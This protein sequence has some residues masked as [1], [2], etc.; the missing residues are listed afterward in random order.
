MPALHR[1]DREFRRSRHARC[2]PAVEPMEARVLLAAGDLDLTFGIEGRVVSDF[3]GRVNVANDIAIQADGKIVVAGL[4]STPSSDTGFDFAVARYNSDGTLDATFGVGGIVTTDFDGWDDIAYSVLVQPDGKIVAA[5]GAEVNVDGSYVNP[6]V[7]LVRYNAD[8]SLDTTFGVDGRVVVV[9]GFGFSSSFLQDIALQ[10]DGRIV[11]AGSGSESSGASDFLIARFEA[12]GELD[13]TFGDAGIAFTDFFGGSDAAYGLAIQADGKIVAV[14]RA[15]ESE[16]TTVAAFARYNL[17]GSLDTTFA[18]GSVVGDG[19]QVFESNFSVTEARSVVLDPSDD[20]IIAAG[21]AGERASFSNGFSVARFTVLRLDTE[22]SPIG[23]M[24]GQFVPGPQSVVNDLAIDSEGRIII[25]GYVEP[26]APDPIPV[27]FALARLNS[28]LSMDLSFGSDG[29]VVTDFPGPP[30]PSRDSL[31]NAVAI[32]P[33][34]RI[35]AVGDFAAPGEDVDFALARYQVGLTGSF[36]FSSVT[37]HV[38]E[39]IGVALIPVLRTGGAEGTVTVQFSATPGTAAPPDFTPVLLTLTFEDGEVLQEVGIN[40]INDGI[41]EPDESIILTLFDPTNGA[42]LG[43]PSVAEMFILDDDSP[44]RLSIAPNVT[45]VE[46]D[47]GAT[48]VTL[49]ISLVGSTEVPASVVVSLVDGT[50]VAGLDFVYQPPRVLVFEPGIT[51][52]TYEVEV[53]GDL[54]IE[55]TEYFGVQ[56]S[57]PIES[58][59]EAGVALIFIEDDDST[60]VLNTNDSGIGSLR[61]AIEVANATPDRQVIDFAI[62]GPGPHTI[63]PLSS[64]PAITD[65]VSID[66]RSQDGYAGTPLIEIAGHML[67]EPLD[68]NGLKIQAAYTLVC[69]IAINRFPGAGIRAEGADY[70]IVDS[71]HIGTDPSGRV[72]LGNSAAGILLINSSNGIIGGFAPEYRNVISGNRGFGGIAIIALGEGGQAT[73]NRIQNNFVGTDASG[74][75]AL[76]NSYGI[77]LSG[78]GSNVIGGSFWSAPPNVV[79]GNRFGG[80]MLTSFSAGNVIAD[81]LIGTNPTGDA[82]VGNL[83]PGIAFEQSPSNVIGEQ[84]TRASNVVSGNLGPGILIAGS[85]SNGNIVWSNHIGTNRSGATPLGNSG[86]GI[87]IVNAAS[88]QVT[89]N[90]I[91]ANEI[92]VELSGASTA[93]SITSNRIGTDVE[94]IRRLPNQ[95]GVFVEN[96]FGN[97]IGASGVGNLISGNALVGV[98]LTGPTASGNVVSNNRI[99]TDADGTSRLPNGFDGVFLQAPNN[100]VSAN[101]ISGNASV[102]VQLFS[103]LA[104]GNIVQSNLIGTDLTGMEPLGNIRDGVY[105]NNA[106]GNQLLDNVVSA[107]G[108]VGVQ[109]FG[110]GTSN[111]VLASNRIGTNALGQV[112]RGLGNNFG[113]FINTISRNTLSPTNRIAGNRVL[114]VFVSPFPVNPIEVANRVENRNQRL[115]ATTEPLPRG[116]MSEFRAGLI[117]PN[118]RFP[119]LVR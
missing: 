62:P 71:S 109:L 96:A 98:R 79:S 74:Q 5:G 34:G 30:D 14:G 39:S 51:E 91:S 66:G 87:W 21:V 16:T 31:I 73:N 47:L 28:D 17:D 1:T 84:G 113:L 90:L 40:I 2:T 94:G 19:K 101:L 45:V 72:S 104:T 119:F 11:G 49:T 8:G 38:D 112:S 78:A 103:E 85:G 56:L 68:D 99:G 36:Q 20:S 97:Q 43:T 3:G 75:I 37:Y 7:A 64:L 60:T 76:G 107:N 70:L 106:P 6:R 108:S 86:A 89:D 18:S 105:F 116:P 4:A 35:V 22:G 10:P 81:N 29:A 117:A 110:L 41:Y 23:S 100:V 46:G 57:D 69:A 33:D 42:V 114:D 15:E 88:N 25:G 13:S 82:P 26:E 118:R 58:T 48:T 9:P 102:G 65:P 77:L 54:V 95:I 44:P 12:D 93:N 24:I 115:K 111:N 53:I 50:A 61:R 92:G 63:A 32:Q 67:L 83:G 27:R 59:I 80:I 52:L 55:N